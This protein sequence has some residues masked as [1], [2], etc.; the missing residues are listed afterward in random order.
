[1]LEQLPEHPVKDAGNVACAV[2]SASAQRMEGRKSAEDAD[3][4]TAVCA[5][6]NFFWQTFYIS[7]DDEP[8]FDE[9]PFVSWRINS[10]RKP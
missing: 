3:I 10:W 9:P 2:L 7:A 1:M 5:A 6:G 4:T 8:P